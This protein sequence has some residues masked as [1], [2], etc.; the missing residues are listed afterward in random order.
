MKKLLIVLAILVGSTFCIILYLLK[1]DPNKKIVSVP[2]TSI[3]VRNDYDSSVTVYVTLGDVAGCIQNVLD[4]PFVTDTVPGQKGLQGTFILQPHDSTISFNSGEL[5]L[6]GVISFMYA[7]DNCSSPNYPLGINQFEFI[8]NN[9][10]QAGS[11]Q[12]SIDISCVHG[13]N[14]VIRVNLDTDKFFNAGPIYPRV[15]SFGNTLNR[16]QIGLAGVYPYGC[17]TCTMWKSPPTCIQLPQVPQK[18]KICQIQRP[19]QNK[20]GVIRV[21]YLGQ[22]VPLK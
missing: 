16:N 13:V 1:T 19:A 15:S 9:T 2:G 6:D 4:I 7:P 21:I 3:Q 11:P 17:D 18:E 10:F 20:G 14:C 22:S 8:I 12:E 5:G